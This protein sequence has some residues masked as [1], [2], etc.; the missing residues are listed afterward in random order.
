[1]NGHY[2]ECFSWQ[3]MWIKTHILVMSCAW[4]YKQLLLSQD[5]VL[6]QFTVR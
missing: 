5:A 2:E 6:A 4:K 1:M 3:F